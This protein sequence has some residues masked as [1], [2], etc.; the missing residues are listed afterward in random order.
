M[1]RSEIV[2][3]DRETNAKKSV[4]GYLATVKTHGLI[5]LTTLRYP[6]ARRAIAVANAGAPIF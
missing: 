2:Q 5:V 3:P 4:K 6:E 1:A